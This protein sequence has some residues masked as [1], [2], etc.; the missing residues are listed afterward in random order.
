MK[1][2]IIYK[3]KKVVKNASKNCL[4]ALQIKSNIQAGN[5]GSDY[6]ACLSSGGSNCDASYQQCVANKG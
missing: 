6:M 4:P 5:C 1:N 2:L 3:S